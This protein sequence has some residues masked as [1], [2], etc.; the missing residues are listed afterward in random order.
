MHKIRQ[1]Q[2][3]TLINWID[4]AYQ[5]CVRD[6][7]LVP[8]AELERLT[9][10]IFTE[11]LLNGKIAKE[12]R[13]QTYVGSCCYCG[14]GIRLEV[15]IPR[16][17]RWQWWWSVEYH[18]NSGCEGD[19]RNGSS[20]RDWGS[21]LVPQNSLPS[22]AFA[23]FCA[24]K[25]AVGNRTSGQGTGSDNWWPAFPVKSLGDLQPVCSRKT[26]Q[27]RLCELKE[28]CRGRRVRNSRKLTELL[29]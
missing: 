21:N 26:L 3:E 11:G 5:T 14:Q 29:Y 10:W 9:S 1:Y 6:N 4:R 19:Q 15:E 8:E 25:Y 28:F 17:Q 22:S 16:N 24:A 2:G 7:P 20:N 27:P 12:W 23:S 18:S 13:R